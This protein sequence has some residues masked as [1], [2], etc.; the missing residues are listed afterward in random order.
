MTKGHF[1][2][3]LRMISSD[4]CE[5]LF[6]T[7]IH[8]SSLLDIAGCLVLRP[9]SEARVTS[10][11]SVT[12]FYVASCITLIEYL[13]IFR[14]INKI[15]FVKKNNDCRIENCIVLHSRYEKPLRFNCKARTVPI[16]RSVYVIKLHR[17]LRFLKT[18]QSNATIRNFQL[19]NG[20]G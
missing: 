8:E 13:Y 14:D 12:S 10:P 11:H 1:I 6:T 3:F 15:S 7:C 4:S 17:V 9:N 5:F 19:I 16:N 18:M 20:I 2:P